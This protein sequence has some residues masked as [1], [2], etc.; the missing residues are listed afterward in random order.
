MLFWLW[1]GSSPEKRLSSLLSKL[2]RLHR[3]YFDLMDLYL[4]SH[5]MMWSWLD[6][7]TSS[8][9]GIFQVYD[10]QFSPNQTVD[11]FFWWKDWLPWIS[12]GQDT[13]PSTWIALTPDLLSYYSFYRRFNAIANWSNQETFCHESC[14][15]CPFHWPSDHFLTPRCLGC[16]PVSPRGSP[17]L[18]PVHELAWYCRL[19]YVLLG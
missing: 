6:S 19:N 3:T 2:S 14:V 8:M 7:A 10:N 17:A 15:W 11:C 9:P 1:P 13:W 5:L 18:S 12:W 16:Q 4:C